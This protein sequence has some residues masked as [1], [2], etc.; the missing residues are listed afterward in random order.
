MFDSSLM[1]LLNRPGI[2]GDISL[3]GDWFWD[4]GTDFRQRFRE[5]AVRLVERLYIVIKSIDLAIP[6]SQILPGERRF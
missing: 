1:I 2:T 3:R 4:S 6:S 5:R